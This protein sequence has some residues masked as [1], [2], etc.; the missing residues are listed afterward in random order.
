MMTEREKMEQGIL[1]DAMNDQKL[2]EARNRAHDLCWQFNQLKPSE[3][4]AASDFLKQLLGSTG[5]HVRI[6]NGFWCD[7]GYNIHVGEK[8]YAN[9]GL[10]IL[11]EAPVTFGHDVFIGPDCGF[12]TAGHPLDTARR[13][14]GL[15]YAWPITVGDN[16]WFGA[17]VQVMPGV[18]I[19]SDSIIG[20]GSVVTKDIPSGSVAVGNPCHVLRKITEADSHTVFEYKKA[21]H[22]SA[23]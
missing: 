7:Y 9:R 4:T 12:H 16:V 23:V 5:E 19:G 15:E 14:L 3:R 1:Y 18:R 20:A 8:F 6:V 21:M 10:T 17:G 11:D 2:I 13:N 22:T